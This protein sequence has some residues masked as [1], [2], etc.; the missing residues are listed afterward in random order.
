MP[1]KEH[2]TTLEKGEEG[3]RK[4]GKEEAERNSKSNVTNRNKEWNCTDYM[5]YTSHTNYANKNLWEF[6][7]LSINNIREN[8]NK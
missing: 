2:G 4:G 3:E 6:Q 5:G 1:H 7:H 8:P